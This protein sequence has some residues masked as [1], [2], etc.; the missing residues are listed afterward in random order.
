MS[1]NGYIDSSLQYPIRSEALDLFLL[2]S[3]EQDA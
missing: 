3:H 2:Y 1:E